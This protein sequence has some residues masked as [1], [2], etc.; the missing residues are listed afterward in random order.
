M[1]KNKVFL[2][3]DYADCSKERDEQTSPPPPPPLAAVVQSVRL[4]VRLRANDS[5]K[6]EDNKK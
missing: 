4:L 6:G 5:F 1:A 3:S 2:S